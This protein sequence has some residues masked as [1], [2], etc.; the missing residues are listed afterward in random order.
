RDEDLLHI[1]VEDN[2]VGRTEA[3]RLKSKSATTHKSH[4]LKITAERMDIVNRIYNVDAK[5]DITDVQGSNGSPDGTRVSLTL[6]DKMYD[7]YH[8]G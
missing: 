4:G 7:S 5:V 8:R 1:Q 2:G 3:A 6:L